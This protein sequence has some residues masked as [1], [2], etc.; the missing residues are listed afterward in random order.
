[1]APVLIKYNAELLEA[2]SS[3]KILTIMGL[4]GSLNIFSVDY[5]IKENEAQIASIKQSLANAKSASD[6]AFYKTELLKA[7][8]RLR[9]LK[10]Q[11]KKK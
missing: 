10:E 9:V 11:K 7:K 2:E 5:G 6:K 4:L 3:I 8:E 1:M